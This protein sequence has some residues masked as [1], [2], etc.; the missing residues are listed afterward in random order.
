MQ[1]TASAR[2]DDV[3]AMTQLITGV[4]YP[5]IGNYWKIFMLKR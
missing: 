5:N 3:A 2:V 1:K 4:H